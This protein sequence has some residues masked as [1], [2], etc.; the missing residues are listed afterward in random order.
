MEEY[1]YRDAANSCTHEYL[2]P[3]VLA[4]LGEPAGPV[5]DLGCG[6]GWLSAALMQRGFDVYGVDASVSGIAVANTR[7]PGRFHV[8][9]IGRQELPSALKEI[10]FQTVI[11]TEVIEHLYDPRSLLQLAKVMLRGVAGRRFI[12]TTPYHGYL[13]NLALALTGELERHFTV[14][15]DGGHIKFF[16]R[17]SLE[18]MLREQGFEPKRFVGAGRAPYL[19]RSMVIAAEVA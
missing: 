14:S 16:S 15:W 6:N 12:V 11:S 19:W 10:E 2:L 17:A 5:L 3:A 13:K 7:H 8:M 18:A 9:E 4:V 1:A